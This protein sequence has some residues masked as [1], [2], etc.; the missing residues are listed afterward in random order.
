MNEIGI[1]MAENR[2]LRAEHA[3]TPLPAP[4]ADPV[5]TP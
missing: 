4:P 1:L 5:E 2:D 3:R